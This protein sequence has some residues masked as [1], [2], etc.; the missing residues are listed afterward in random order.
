MTDTNFP[1]NNDFLEDDDLFSALR[2]DNTPPETS[3]ELFPDETILPEEEQFP[4][5]YPESPEDAYAGDAYAE[6]AYAEN[7]YPVE[8]DTVADD[9]FHADLTVP[10]TAEE[11]AADDHAMYS[12]GLTHPEDAQF[13][14][15]DDD[16]DFRRLFED[17]E[18][19][20]ETVPAPAEEAP[21]YTDPAEPEE[22][23][24]AEPE[25]APVRRS[26]RERPVRK[27]RPKHRKGSGLFSLPQLAASAVWLLIVLA[28]GVSL[29]RLIW[30][31]AADVLAFGR[32]ERTVTVSITADDTMDTIAQKLHDAGLIR[33]QG[34]F[35]LYADLSHAEKKI[36][37]GTFSLSTIYDYHALVNMM[38]PRAGNRAVVEDVLI[39]EGFTCR[40]IFALLEEKG[41]CKAADLEAW[42]AD[43]E[44]KDYWFLEDVPRGSKYCLEG[45][46]FP[47]TYDFYE[48]STPKQA[49]E[50]MLDGFNYRVTEE[51]M[52]ELDALNEHLAAM[53][54]ENGSGEDFIAANRFT[55][56]EL[57]TVASLIE[58]ETAGNDESPTIASV[59]YNRLFLWGDTPRYLNI[60]ASVIYA[61][62]GKTDLTAAD[63]GVDSPYNTYTN[64]G[65]TPGPIANPGVS[66]LKAALHPEETPY[67]YYVLDP[68]AGTHIF[69]KTLEEH[70]K[71]VEKVKERVQDEEA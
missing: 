51:L 63:M 64:T 5:A 23:L 21:V 53:M 29:G 39:P 68:E 20:P 47:D 15:G 49:L 52:P 33:Y 66:S 35:K 59:I 24:P 2:A 69:S 13:R 70:E 56:H 28:I 9:P 14:F 36:T 17:S 40:Q 38:S 45:Y 48:N 32:E 7:D 25:E 41:I 71:N 65:L 3:D 22:E 50:K 58:K 54:R 4:D 37:T 27:G 30:V 8:E 1:E 10:E 60:D 34:L 12:A 55:L 26:R 31:C 16:A 18:P 57:I 19:A 61:L 42:A 67:Y 62:E 44:L 46:L 43:G 6:D 11:L